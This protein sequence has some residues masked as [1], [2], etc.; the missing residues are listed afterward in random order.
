[1]CLCRVWLFCSCSWLVAP[2]FKVL[3]SLEWLRLEGLFGACPAQS[4]AQS[5]LETS[6]LPRLLHCQQPC[7]TCALAQQVHLN[8]LVWSKSLL[9]PGILMEFMCWLGPGGGSMEQHRPS[10][11]C[12]LPSQVL[13][14]EG[15]SSSGV[16]PVTPNSVQEPSKA[17]FS[18]PSV[19][20]S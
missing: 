12:S 2:G 10:Q 13:P 4:P 9:L 6:P 19:V 3:C 14:M 17:S 1:M 8:L 7:V 15:S 16:Q 11:R 5:S 20:A 18:G